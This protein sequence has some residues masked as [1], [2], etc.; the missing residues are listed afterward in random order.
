MPPESSPEVVDNSLTVENA[1][2]TPA[3]TQEQAKNS[4][5]NAASSSSAEPQ[6]A[7]T[8]L[9]AVEAALKPKDA[10][11]ASKTPGEAEAKAE[12]DDSNKA[13]KTEEDDLS[14]DE[15]KALGEKVQRRIRGFTSKLKAKDEQLAA[16]E[17][18]AKE[19]DK[20]TTAIRN[21]GMSNQEVGEL[22]TVGTLMKSGD[23]RG[24]I[25]RI[26]PIYEALLKAAGEELPPELQEKVRLGYMT[27]EDAKA[28]S[29][30]SA[31]AQSS[32]QRLERSEQEKQAAE[33]KKEREE[34]VQ[35]TLTAIETWEA[36]QAK[37]DPDW[38]QK[39]QE[40]SEL[41]D[42]AIT[43]KQ[44]EL[45]Q[46]WFPSAEEAVAMSKEALK[47]VEKRY[48]R[49]KQN[50]KEQHQVQGDA[51]ARSKAAPKSMLDVVNMGAA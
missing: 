5:G 11:P 41:V 38:H 14:E 30:A 31:D 34:V 7:E 23:A 44:R 20:I 18:K 28:L 36:A 22:L 25:E 40:V 16:L 4:D 29:R 35:K 2:A 6:K 27:E 15:F 24:A 32:K 37:A 17:P 39:R 12:T 47:T 48:S 33:E 3:N 50:P 8:M 26:K 21:T 46:P 42:L 10:S 51:S 1:A 43:K 13:E 9:D 49:F 19:Y 45:N